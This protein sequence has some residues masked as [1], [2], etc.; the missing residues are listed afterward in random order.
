MQDLH[1]RHRVDMV[2]VNNIDPIAFYHKW[3]DEYLKVG[4]NEAQVKANRTS[5]YIKNVTK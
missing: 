3:N 1:L 5:D 2:Y 4:M